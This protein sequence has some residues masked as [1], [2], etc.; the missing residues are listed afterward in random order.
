MSLSD[1]IFIF[2]FLPVALGLYY[3]AKD[4]FK[5]Y[6]LVALSFF[7]Y[8]LSSE[9]CFLVLLVLTAFTILMGRCI[10]KSTNKNISRVLLVAGI[11]ANVLVLCFYKYWSAINFGWEKIFGTTFFKEEIV[12]MLGIS[13]FAFKAIS[14]LADIYT[15]KIKPEK[16]PI[17]DALYLTFFGQIISGPISRYDEMTNK[18]L[19][20]N[21]KKLRFD[22][23]SEGV[24]RF[25][26]GLCKKMI[27]ADNLYRVV[28][29]VFES[30]LNTISMPY[31]WLGSICFSLQLF[32]D[33]AGYSDMAIGITKMFGFDCKENFIY[34]Y[35]SDSISGFWRRWHISLSFW[36]RDYIYIPLGGSRNKKEIRT[37]LNLFCVWI[38]TG[39]WHG[40]S[41]N[42]VVWGLGYFV[43]ISFEKITKLPGSLKSGFGKAMYRVFSLFCINL[44][45]VMFNA[46]G[47]KEGLK[48]I[49][50]MFSFRF[51]TVQSTRTIVLLKEYGI[52]VALAILFCMPVADYVKEKLSGSK[53]GIRVYNVVSFLAIALVFILS[54]ALSVSGNNNPFTYA[55]F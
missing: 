43:L 34:P 53:V 2:C 33:F 32:F 9:S 29:E 40:A 23:F 13:F 21:D 47:F 3:I 49:K 5:E 37:Y 15:K 10:A 36:F 48:F 27:I 4:E 16:N 6:I 18:M 54:V 11:A 12:V 30:D 38:L 26:V 55:N 22:Y 28:S 7:F 24:Y 35:I 42:F 1:S 31:A 44:L 17:H 19:L 14:Y 20:L 46:S 39:I 50:G 41:I 51:D 45:W 8:A 25:M 52:L